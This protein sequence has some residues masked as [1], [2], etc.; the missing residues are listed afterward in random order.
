MPRNGNRLLASLSTD[1]F[2]LLEAHLQSVTLGMRK[3]LERPNRRIEAAYFPEGGF[4]SVVAV[5]S[6]GKQVEVG[7]I[8]RE[9]M[10]GLPIVFGDHRSPH[11]TY[12]QA[13]GM[14]Q[15]IAATEL[16]K[17]MQ[18]SPSLRDSLLKF[19]QAFGVQTTHTAVS[20]AQSRLDVRLARWLLMAHDRIGEDTLPLTHEFLSLMLAVRRPGVTEALRALQEQ[21]L[22][23]Y[24]RGQI[25]V[26]DRKGMERT[27]G[28]AYGVPEA[29][30]R[31][32][33][34]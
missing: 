10:T 17:A 5:Q 21:G 13:S 31:R 18:A 1:D 22:I 16:R 14:G 19:A 24:G 11:A 28:K 26:K 3:H 4:A 32:L 27:A 7:L 2:D 20:N 23:A 6:N 25:T 12:I 15:C 34:G 8:G 29:E 9:G 30:Y 33:I